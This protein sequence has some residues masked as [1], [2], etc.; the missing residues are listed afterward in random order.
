[1]K[2]TTCANIVRSLVEHGYLES[3]GPRRG[4]CLGPK[5]FHLTRNAP[6]R[7]DLIDAARPH[8]QELV[9]GINE[10]CLLSVLRANR[11]YVLFHVVH[12]S[13]LQIRTE[14]IREEDPCETPTGRLLIA[15]LSVAERDRFVDAAGFPGSRWNDIESRE[16]LEIA[17]DGILR[18]GYCVKDPDQGES[19]AGVA[20]P[21]RHA[22]D[23]AALGVF[24][25]SDRFKGKHKKGI[26]A[27]MR[28]TSQRIAESLE[29]EEL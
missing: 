4:Y 8:M 6:Y 1:V 7:K 19:L 18:A 26:L 22:E 25:L 27:S 12:D 10:T 28:Q 9:E 16:E 24:L 15:H 3:V 5:P 20:F 17:C 13:P 23:L 2:A 29:A 14:F 21:V 11:R